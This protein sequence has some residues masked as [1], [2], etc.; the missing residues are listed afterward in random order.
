MVKRKAFHCSVNPIMLS[1]KLGEKKRNGEKNV[2]VLLEMDRKDNQDGRIG[3]GH[4]Y[5][6]GEIL[7]SVKQRGHIPGNWR[8]Q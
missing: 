2:P 8:D 4:V 7:G 1:E 5:T 6:D 3:Q